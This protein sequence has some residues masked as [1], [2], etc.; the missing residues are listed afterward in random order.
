MSSNVCFLL[1]YVNFYKWVSL[2]IPEK[3]TSIHLNLFLGP[4]F[5][6]MNCCIA[7]NLYWF[8][9]YV[10]VVSLTEF[11]EF[12]NRKK[13][14]SNVFASSCRHQKSEFRYHNTR[15]SHDRS[16]ALDF[17]R[18]NLMFCF[19]N[20]VLHKHCWVQLCSCCCFWAVVTLEFSQVFF[21]NKK[22][23]HQK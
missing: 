10:V 5:F 9:F 12:T 1:N 11:R 3:T 20:L 18:P 16:V 19:D 4:I 21:F 14:I 23:W 15:I 8:P 2:R 7:P 6:V 13:N 22:S 17:K